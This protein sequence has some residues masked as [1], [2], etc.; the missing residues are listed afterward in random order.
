[1]L[2]H[3]YHVLAYHVAELRIEINVTDYRNYSGLNVDENP[4]FC[5]ACAVLNQSNSQ[6]NSVMVALWVDYKS[7]DA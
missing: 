6:A 5:D 2:M 4:D 1:M 3:D 7:V